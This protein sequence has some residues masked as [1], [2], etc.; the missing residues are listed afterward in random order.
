MSEVTESAPR[1]KVNFHTS[2]T[3]DGK[4][5]Y[6]VDVE[7]GVTEAEV[8]EVVRLA[9]LA[10]KQCREALGLDVSLVAALEASIAQRVTTPTGATT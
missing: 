7:N 6:E 5:A 9:V 8:N 2:S 10:R 3:K 4:E 1:V